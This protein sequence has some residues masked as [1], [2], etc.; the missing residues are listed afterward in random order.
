MTKACKPLSS[1]FITIFVSIALASCGSDTPKPQKEET[2]G[3]DLWIPI[4]GSSGKST[5]N[6]DP[7]IIARVADLTRGAL[8]IKGQGVETSASPLT[9]YVV[10]HKGYYYNVS[11]EGR[12][13]KF[14]ISTTGVETVKEIPMPQILD[15]RFSHAW[16]DDSTLLMISAAGDKQEVAWV[17]VDISKMAVIARGTLDLP[18]PHEGEAFNSSGLLGYRKSDGIL[19]YPH[20]Y[21]VKSK[22]NAM[23]LA[24]K[25]KE[26]YL[27]FIEVSTMQV[28]KI[29]KDTRCEMIGS[30]SFGE[31][32]CQKTFFD[33]E[34]N[35]YFVAATCQI[36]EKA[37]K[38]SIS[39]QRSFLFRVNAGSMETDKS[40]NGYNQPRG[41]I[42]NVTPISD[43]DVLL[44]IQDPNFKESGN[45]DWSSKTNRYIYYWSRCNIET[46]QCGHIKEIPFSNGN[47]GPLA[48]KV[49]NMVY[50]GANIANAPTTIYQYD[51]SSHQV[52]KGATLAEGFELDRLQSVGH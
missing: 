16:L 28:K 45:T 37:K 29:D 51:I 11:R 48:V 32:R 25:R 52:T 6:Q 35:F 42:I 10:Y 17:K 31:T 19:I 14:R 21:M 20:V 50:I 47:Y 44:Y 30:T 46:Q 23:D 15:R 22:K 36:P 5:A 41:K 38:V 9:P 27:A 43:T 24:P 4:D 49:G 3:Y 12:F 2:M 18:K 34:G 8:S 39:R 1:L 13:G 33:A 7:H 26:I 40:Y